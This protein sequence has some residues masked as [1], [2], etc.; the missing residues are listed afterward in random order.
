MGRSGGTYT[1]APKVYTVDV[2][3]VRIFLELDLLR[4]WRTYY[5]LKRRKRGG[6]RLRRRGELYAVGASLVLSN[7]MYLLRFPPRTSRS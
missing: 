6:V 4:C 3:S 5:G 1:H 2:I 7:D